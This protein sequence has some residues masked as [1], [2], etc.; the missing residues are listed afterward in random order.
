MGVG[1]H[2]SVYPFWVCLTPK[3]AQIILFEKESKTKPFF[4]GLLKKIVTAQVVSRC[5][6]FYRIFLDVGIGF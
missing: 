2:F 4:N 3:I 6:Y 5:R 1:Y